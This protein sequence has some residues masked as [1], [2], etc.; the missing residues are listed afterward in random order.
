MDSFQVRNLLKFSAAPQDNG[1]NPGNI[2][3]QPDLS[4]LELMIDGGPV[5]DDFADAEVISSVPAFLV[6]NTRQAT[7]EPSEP[8]PTCV[9]SSGF[10]AW[11]R[12]DPSL[13]TLYE[14]DSFG[15]DFDTVL[16]VHTGSALGD[17]TEHVCNDDDFQTVASKVQFVGHPGTTYYIRIASSGSTPAGT[18]HMQLHAPFDV[19]GDGIVVFIDN[20]HAVYNP[21]QENRDDEPLL[22]AFS[23][24][25]PAIIPPNDHTR[26]NGDG[27]GDACDDD[28]DNDG[29]TDDIEA[30]LGVPSPPGPCPHATAPT[31][32]MEA[33]TDDDR[34]TDG[35]ECAL[36]TDPA[37]PASKLPAIPP[38]DGD[39]DG[40]PDVFEAVLGTST[41]TQD[42]NGDGR[43]DGIDSDLDGI[44]DGVE[45]RGYNSSPLASDTDLDGC[46]DG[47]ESRPST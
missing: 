36:G 35:A 45:Y 34:M 20:C 24:P 29:L 32:P 39:A 9:A 4:L 38:G 7:L 26:P 25:P 33:D 27:L 1:G 23:T 13:S 21:L 12:F 42:L 46:S 41:S 44:R 37:N 5:N 11:Y 22:G 6:R 16:S 28:D 14:F 43:A 8:N 30:Q 47:R 18:A 15:S 31:N 40:L 10:S 3:P 2:G 17:L 19:D